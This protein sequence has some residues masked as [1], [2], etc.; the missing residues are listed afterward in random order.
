M[1]QALPTSIAEHPRIDQWVTFGEDGVVRVRSGRVEIGQGIATAMVQIA[2]EELDVR[3]DQVHLVSGDTRE[4]PDE[5]FTSGS[6]SIEVGGMSVRFAA[7]AARHVLLAEAAKLLQST[8]DKL[9]V[10]DGQVHTDNRPT[11]L[12]YW[13]LA[14]SVDLGVD[15]E[16][17]A[18]PKAPSEHKLVGTTLPR[19][20]LP[21]KVKGPAFIQDLT[22]PGMLHGRVLHPPAMNS[23]LTAIDLDAL[24]AQPGVVEVARNGSFLGVVAESEWAALKAI[25]RAEALAQWEHGAL[26]PDDVVA[27]VK[28][29]TAEMQ[30]VFEAGDPGKLDGRRF[31]TLITR[32]YIAHGS[33][34]TSCAVAQWEGDHLQVFNHSQ[35]VFPLRA[36]L[37]EVFAVAPETIDVAH[38]PGAG[39]YGH[40][41]ADDVALDAAL[42]ARA[43]PG[44]PVRVVWNRGDELGSG[45]LGPAMATRVEAVL[46]D[47]HKLMG[48]T[49][50]IKSQPHGMRPGRSGSVNLLSAIHLDPPLPRAQGSDVPFARGGGADRNAVPTYAIPNVCVGK[51]IIH[52]LPVRGSSL[53]GLGAFV[54]VIAIETLMDDIAHEIGVD[55][56]VLRLEN[57]ED[58]RARTVI[59]HAAEMCGWPGEEEGEGAALGLAFARYKNRGNYCAVAVR[60]EVDE[61]VR[62]THAWTSADAGALINPDG[63][64]NQIE[65]GIVQ[66]ASWALKEGVRFEDGLIVTRDWETYPIL[67]FSEVPSIEIDIVQRP[68][69]KEFGVGE[70]SVG[71]TGAA[72]GNAIRRALGVR[73]RD[74]PF[75]RDAIIAALG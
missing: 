58:D 26:P 71:P 6:R 70:A 50:E 53:R 67:R 57:L 15:V 73:V 37:A 60:V 63:V 31:E 9:S 25:A 30:T 5:G 74:L 7:S 40:N 20:D 18:K 66:G 68:N 39:C 22:L 65:G 41:A 28:A 24:R 16:Q 29:T 49:A 55:P 43:V 38:V 11:D 17:Y 62:V 54:N 51:R 56:V 33:I 14:R 61:A 42:L 1:T 72:I 52:D 21:A 59:E 10:V 36:A 45:P 4:G 8:P 46:G 23:K 44:K 27:A 35:G 34:G 64:A 13:T 69:E 47:G 48:L 75:T 3:P 19:Q 12:T 32:P 2:A